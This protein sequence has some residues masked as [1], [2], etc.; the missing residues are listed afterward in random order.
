MSGII[1][2]SERL[3]SRIGGS[4]AGLPS[5]ILV[6]LIFIDFT[7]GSHSAQAAVSIVPLIFMASLAYGVV[8]IGAGKRIGYAG[9]SLKLSLLAALAWLVVVIPEK[10]AFGD[11]HFYVIYLIALAGLLLFRFLV[12]NFNSILPS[13]LP[14]P[15][16]IYILRFVVGGMVIAASV[17][18]ARLL[19]PVWGGVVSSFPGLLGTVLYFL[20]KSQ[21]GRFLEGFVR[22]LPASYFSSFIFLIVVHQTILKIADGWSFALGLLGA[23]VYTSLIIFY[24]DIE[25]T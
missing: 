13:K 14:L 24:R 12:K 10:F 17:I 6:G 22:R 19:G 2:A 7:E 23:V 4:L 25:N 21:S 15:R 1:W 11:L 5:T 3:G 8:F 16:H 9:N 20:N 18:V